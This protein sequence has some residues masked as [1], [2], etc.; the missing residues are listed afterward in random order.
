[1]KQGIEALNDGDLDAII[2]FKTFKERLI[3]FSEKQSAATDGR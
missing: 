2:F 1:V 3:F